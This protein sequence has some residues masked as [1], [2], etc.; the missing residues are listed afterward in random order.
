MKVSSIVL[1][2]LI[3]G[4]FG[5]PAIADPSA[6]AKDANSEASEVVE[7]VADSTAEVVESAQAE[8]SSD[9]DRPVTI[10]D[11]PLD[12]TSIETF[13]AGLEKV[14]EEA[15]EQEYRSLMSALSYLLFYDI[16]AEMNKAKLYSRLDGKTPNQI[17]ARVGKSRK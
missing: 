2:L 6:T 8:Q 4:L 11:Q 12:G 7:T 13:T 1:L 15:S 17:L 14:D 3:F 9:K 10:M 16:G 5:N